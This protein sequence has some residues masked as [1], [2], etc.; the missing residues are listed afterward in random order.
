MAYQIEISNLSYRPAA[1][2]AEQPDILRGISLIIEKGSF[3]AL[4]GAN[5]SGK[6]TLI[7]HIN[8][9]LLPSNGSVIVEGLDTKDPQSSKKL[10]SLVGMVFQDPAHQ[11]VA[12]TVEEDIAFGLENLNL[13]TRTIQSIVKEQLVAAGLTE[14]AT[15]PPHLL[16]GGQIQKLALAGVLARQPSIILF[17]EPTSMLDP[18]SRMQFMATVLDLKKRGLTVM[19][20]THHMEEAVNADRVIVMSEG[21]VILDGLPNEIFIEKDKLYEI[22]LETPESQKYVEGFRRLGWRIPGNLLQAEELFQYLPGYEG[23]QLATPTGS[24]ARGNG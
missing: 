24:T 2:P 12:S 9:L 13:P 1:F 14:D 10:R 15:R 20:V 23:K 17:D 5:G 16:S 19:L 3:I 8:G 7:K 4:V 21:R 11:I 6:T 18:V 22:G